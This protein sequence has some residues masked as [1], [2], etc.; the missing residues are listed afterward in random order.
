MRLYRDP[1]AQEGI[2]L[3]SREKGFVF[4]AS[5]QGVMW[6][7]DY[8]TDRRTGLGVK[9]RPDF[10]DHPA[11]VH[12]V[13]PRAGELPLPGFVDPDRGERIWVAFLLRRF[14]PRQ[15]RATLCRPSTLACFRDLG[16]RLVRR[17][18]MGARVA[19]CVG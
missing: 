1:L 17:V 9:L 11:R 4:D 12:L 7:S 6:P 8:C 10:R 19:V 14:G 15:M 13:R 2:A 3:L 18:R 16:V 5:E